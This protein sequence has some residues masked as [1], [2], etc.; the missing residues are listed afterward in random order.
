MNGRICIDVRSCKP[1]KSLP[2]LHMQN[3]MPSSEYCSRPK[4]DTL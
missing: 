4:S 3:T 1:T 2:T